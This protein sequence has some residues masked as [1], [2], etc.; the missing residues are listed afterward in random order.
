MPGRVPRRSAS[1]A[2]GGRSN[3]RGSLRV[4]GVRR[5]RAAGRVGDGVQVGPQ[6][7]PRYAG[8]P[9]DRDDIFRRDAPR[10]Q[11]ALN[12]GLALPQQSAESRLRTCRATSAGD[13]R[14]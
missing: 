3:E 13:Q 7:V 6:F 1:G 12:R 10:L 5:W 4:S 11:P 9:F 14:I 8:D 2:K